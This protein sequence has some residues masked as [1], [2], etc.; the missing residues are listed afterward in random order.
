MRGYH[1]RIGY[2]GGGG[3][4]KEESRWQSLIRAA[5]NVA[6]RPQRIVDEARRLGAPEQCDQGCC[7]LA[8]F[9]DN[10]AS[11]FS[12]PGHPVSI[13][14][15]EDDRQIMQLASTGDELKYCVRR[16]YVRLVIEEMHRL[17]IEV[18][19]SVV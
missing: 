6:D 2:N 18:S 5:R 1:I 15:Q 8:T 17:N 19:L 11:D 3:A 9:A 7:E 14:D 4:E 12:T 13:I 10:Y 16:A